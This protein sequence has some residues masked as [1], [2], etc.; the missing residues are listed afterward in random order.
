MG[1]LH[2]SMKRQTRLDALRGLAIVAVFLYHYYARWPQFLPFGE[3]FQWAPIFRLGLPGV[4]LFFMISG[5]VIFLTLDNSRSFLEFVSRRWIRLFPA[6]LIAVALIYL[7][8]P[9]LP[10]RPAGAPRLLDALPGLLFFEPGWLAALTGREFQDFEGAFWSLFVEFRFYVIFGVLYFT[11]GAG[12]A[13]RVL[14]VLSLTGFASRLIE[15]RFPPQVA[16][17]SAL[18]FLQTALDLKFLPWFLIGMAAYEFKAVEGCEAIRGR[19]QW[20]LLLLAALPLIFSERRQIHI[21]VILLVAFLYGVFGSGGK[22]IYQSRW[23]LFFGYVSYPLY[24]I[25]ENA[26][27]AL[28]ERTRAL[29]PALPDLLLPLPAIVIVTL[30]ASLIARYGEGPLQRILRALL[31]TRGKARAA[32]AAKAG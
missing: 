7:T 30:V 18:D 15:M 6:M 31:L 14:L 9:W 10:G 4:E 21:L 16:A 1:A 13:S 5:Y 3:R 32:S 26:G 11:L 17:R 19:R 27:V 8:A 22:A 24:L 23:L 28:I 25:H 20:G 12:R 2:E 29:A